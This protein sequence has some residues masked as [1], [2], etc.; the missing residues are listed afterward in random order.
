M[1]KYKVYTLGCKVAQAE[2]MQLKSLLNKFGCFEANAGETP[3][4]CLVNTCAVTS[5]A[6]G[7]SR[8]LLRKLARQYP[9]TKIL[10]LG[11]Y[12]SLADASLISSIPQIVVSADHCQGIFSAVENFLSLCATGKGLLPDSYNNYNN[13]NDNISNLF[14]ASNIKHV[15]T[16]KVKNKFSSS[17]H[18]AFL[19]IQDGCD[20]MCSYCIIPQLRPKLSSVNIADV[21]KQAQELIDAGHKEIVLCGIF[22]GAYGRKTAKR[23]RIKNNNDCLSELIKKLTKLSGLQR[24]RLSSIE[25]LDLTDKLLGILAESDKT[26]GHLHLPLQSGSDTILRRMARQYRKDEYLQAIERIKKY[27]PDVALTTDIIVGFPGETEE[28]FQ[29]TLNLCHQI[30]FLKIH[31]FP[32]SPRKG[33]PAYRWKEQMPDAKVIKD[34]LNRLH[35]LEAELRSKYC[36]QFEGK[37][38]RVLVEHTE[39]RSDIWKCV[40]RAD[41]YFKV[42]FNA[43][44]NLDNELVAVTITKAGEEPLLGKLKRI[45]K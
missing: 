5:T 30:G 36:H 8:R 42:Q 38:V 21:I 25:P 31:I 32:F 7:K 12:A 29:E 10:F 41:Q 35:T 15:F 34:R 27:I 39:Q 17:R 23:S 24:I 43:E 13:N 40:G 22:L 1:I 20:A 33:T 19:K 6:A 45:Y 16:S 44:E 14:P 28:D 26:A 4:L 11:C 37:T 18:R 3:D 2:G 9:K